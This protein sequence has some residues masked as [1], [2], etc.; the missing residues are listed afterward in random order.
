MGRRRAKQ[1]RHGLVPCPDNCGQY[2]DPKKQ[3]YRDCSLRA[4]NRGATR[5]TSDPGIA[6][7]ASVSRS[8]VAG[9]ATRP[10]TAPPSRSAEKK[11]TQRAAA[12]TANRQIISQTVDVPGYVLDLTF[13]P[14]GIYTRVANQFID[15][16]PCR[17]KRRKGHWLCEQLRDAADTI[18]PATW[19]KEVEK[20]TVSSLVIAGFP[21]FMARVLGSG[22]NLGFKM[23]TKRL[24]FANIALLLKA[25]IPLV[26]PDLDQCPTERDVMKAFGAPFISEALQ[27]SIQAV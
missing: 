22:A 13:N 17:R 7:P 14:Q 15:A 19:A 26:C 23:A 1:R 3:P 9:P 4:R 27:H 12:R 20:A 2:H 8:P 24:P 25:L 5:Q 6:R 10:E 16:V 21:V 11:A 18:S